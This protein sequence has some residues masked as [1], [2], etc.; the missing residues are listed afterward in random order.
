MAKGL[1]VS[2]NDDDARQESKPRDDPVHSWPIH[3][4]FHRLNGCRTLD[5]GQHAAKSNCHL[6]HG[7]RSANVECIARSCHLSSGRLGSWKKGSFMHERILRK[8]KE[9]TSSWCFSVP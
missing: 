3:F 9:R 7:E 5:K 8:R 4:E 1:G 6:E 2:I